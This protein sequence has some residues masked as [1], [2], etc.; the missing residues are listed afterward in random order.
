MIS[1]NDVAK[2]HG[3][4][5][6][7]LIIGY[8]AGVKALKFL[9]PADEHDLTAVLYIPRRIPYT[10]IADG[11]QF[12]TGCTYGKGNIAIVNSNDFKILFEKHSTKERLILAINKNFLSN[13]ENM[14]L[15]EAAELAESTKFDEMFV[16]G[17]H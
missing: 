13:V 3:H 16:I 11:V 8:R 10:C 7:F 2:V 15:K 4:K 12:S 5:G 17:Y 14:K 1:L 6:P 9:K